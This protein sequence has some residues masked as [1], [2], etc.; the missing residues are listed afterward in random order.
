MMSPVGPEAAVP[1]ARETPY[2]QQSDIPL[3][4]QVV[5]ELKMRYNSCR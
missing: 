5:F 4:F 1:I 2:C 3:R